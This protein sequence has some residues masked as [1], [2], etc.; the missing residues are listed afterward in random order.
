MMYV[1][2]ALWIPC[3]FILGKCLIKTPYPALPWARTLNGGRQNSGLVLEIITLGKCVTTYPGSCEKVAGQSRRYDCI[4][5][6]GFC[7][8]WKRINFSKNNSVIMIYI[9]RVWRV[10]EILSPLHGQDCNTKMVVFTLS[11]IVSLSCRKKR[12]IISC[13]WMILFHFLSLTDARL[14]TETKCF[15]T[16]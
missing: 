6:V 3:Q 4:C 8:R 15:P 7:F 12:N 13:T 5:W 16:R 14:R 2:M 9:R 1:Q 10:C 11:G